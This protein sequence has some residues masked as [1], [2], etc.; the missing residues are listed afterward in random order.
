LL[1]R[2][3]VPS[4]ADRFTE[5]VAAWPFQAPTAAHLFSAGG[6]LHLLEIAA[7]DPKPA[8]QPT[9]A[10]SQPPIYGIDLRREIVKSEIAELQVYNESCSYCR[11]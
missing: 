10:V 1:T 4:M 8:D 2:L 11:E 9:A 5:A 6:I 7:F 3:L